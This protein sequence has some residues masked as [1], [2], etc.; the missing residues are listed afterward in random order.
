MKQP[1]K[2]NKII[3]YPKYYTPLG[4]MKRRNGIVKFFD[5]TEVNE[6]DYGLNTMCEAN[7]NKHLWLLYPLWSVPVL[8]DNKKHLMC[9]NC[10]KKVVL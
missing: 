10:E 8:K 2:Q 1:Q 7:Y 4:I 9:L 5:G 3:V 6:L